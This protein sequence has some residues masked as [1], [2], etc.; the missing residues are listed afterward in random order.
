MV[1]IH[2]RGEDQEAG[3]EVVVKHAADDPRAGDEERDAARDEREEVAG[4]APA[5]FARGARFA[6]LVVA[7]DPDVLRRVQDG[8]NAAAVARLRNLRVQLQQRGYNEPDKL[9]ERERKGRK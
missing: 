2:D 5:G 1:D 4:Q 6:A 7:G 8:E 9:S 3:G